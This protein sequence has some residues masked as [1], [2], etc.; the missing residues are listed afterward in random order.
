MDNWTMV[1]VM[2]WIR[3]LNY[4]AASDKFTPDPKNLLGCRHACHPALKAKDCIFHLYQK[5]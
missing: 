4:D 5:R 3:G 2:I 1:L